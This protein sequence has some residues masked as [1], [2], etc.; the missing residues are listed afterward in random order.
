M[1]VG[2]MSADRADPVDPVLQKKVNQVVELTGRS[3]DEVIVALH[4]CDNDANRA[5]NHL[6]EGDDQGEWKE[7][8]SKRKKRQPAT[9]KPVEDTS[10]ERREKSTD[11]RR[12]RDDRFDGA[13]SRRGRQPPRLARKN[14]QNREFEENERNRNDSASQ[15]RDR[16][17]FGKDFDKGFDR[18]FDRSF[19]DDRRGRG[20]GRGGGP[21]RGGRGGGRGRREGRGGGPGGPRY[22]R[23]SSGGP[24]IGTWTNESAEK[25]NSQNNFTVSTWEDMATE[26]DWDTEWTGSVGTTT[27]EDRGYTKVNL[28][29]T[30]TFISSAPVTDTFSNDTSSAFTNNTSSAY[31]NDTSSAYTNDTGSNVFG[32]VGADYNQHDDF[33]QNDSIFPSHSSDSASHV[34]TNSLV[35]IAT[36]NGNVAFNDS[37]N[38]LHASALETAM[39]ANA[40]GNTDPLNQNSL[41]DDTMQNSLPASNIGQP[42]TLG[43][44]LDLSMLL[45]SAEAEAHAQKQQSQFISQFTKPQP[46][47][48]YT[49]N[50]NNS[51]PQLPIH[52]ST[53]SLPHHNNV[54]Q[55]LPIH[56]SAQ[57][58]TALQHAALTLNESYGSVDPM[59]VPMSAAES[60]AQVTAGS[61]TITS[62]HSRA[63]QQAALTQ[64]MNQSR[65]KP[66]KSKLPP[67]SKIPATAVEMPGH[68][69]GTMNLDVQFGNWDAGFVSF[70]TVP[71]EQSQSVS[72]SPTISSS[73]PPT[74]HSNHLP[75][76][77]STSDHLAANALHVTSVIH[78]VTSPPPGL[79]VNSVMTTPP[80]A[81]IPASPA[82]SVLD[83]VCSNANIVTSPPKQH[84][85]FP[86]SQTSPQQP[87]YSKP[88]AVTSPPD[89]IPFPSD[90]QP[91][92]YGQRT[93]STGMSTGTSLQ[94]KVGGGAVS[95]PGM[96][97]FPPQPYA[98]SYQVYSNSSTNNKQAVSASDVQSSQISSSSHSQS[99]PTQYPSSFHSAVSPGNAGSVYSNQTAAP[100]S[101]YQA[102]NSQS[103]FPGSQSVPANPS[104]QSPSAYHSRESVQPATVPFPPPSGNSNSQSNSS[105]YSAGAASGAYQSGSSQSSLNQSNVSYSATAGVSQSSNSPYARESQSN[106]QVSSS[107]YTRDSTIIQSQTG[108]QSSYPGQSSQNQQHG[109]YAPSN[110][111][112]SSTN[113]SSYNATPLPVTTQ[114]YTS[115]PIPNNP[116]AATTQSYT[117]HQSSASTYGSTREQTSSQSYGQTPRENPS[118]QSFGPTSRDN[119][120]SYGAPSRDNVPSQSYGS[121]SL[122][123]P[124]SQSYGSRDNAT[125]QSYG[126]TSRDSTSSK[127]YG[128]APRDN[129]APQ[130]YGST[131]RENT[132]SQSY[133]TTS[134]DNT[135]SQSFG[136]SSRDSTPSQS[137][138]SANHQ[139]NSLPMAS[140][141]LTDSLQKMTVKD[142][143]SPSQYG[144]D[145]SNTAAVSTGVIPSTLSTAAPAFTGSPGSVTSVLGLTTSSNTSTLASMPA[146][147][148]TVPGLP[149]TSKAPPNLPPGVPPLM[150]NYIPAG[151]PFT[152]PGLPQQTAIYS[153]EDLQLLQRLPVPPST[154]TGMT[155]PREYAAGDGKGLPTRLDA[156]SPVT[157]GGGP[158]QGGSQQQSQQA[159]TQQATH[160]PF[161]NPTLPPGYNYYYP[162]LVPGGYSAYPPAMFPSNMVPPVTQNTG[163]G[164]SSGGAAQFQKPAGYGG[165]HYGTATYDDLSTQAQDFAKTAYQQ[166]APV[167]SKVGVTSAVTANVSG[168]IAA[169]GKVSYGMTQHAPGFDKAAFAAAT[170]PPFNMAMSASGSQAGPMGPGAY[171]APYMP[172]MAHQPHSQM[173]HHHLQ[174]LQKEVQK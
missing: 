104:Y 39:N 82:Q 100:P 31:T 29:E 154:L 102:Q 67:P 153:Y 148:H 139:T 62:M 134:R 119:T 27:N 126:S 169:A 81:T 157:P 66:Q 44:R 161:M 128:S 158:V 34:F 38:T 69:P 86:N 123:K 137:Y 51:Q 96:P 52:N 35:T 84:S 93:T 49:N 14:N 108:S 152:F 47:E 16:G 142:N 22:D 88:S 56:N 116:H 32:S 19:G 48:S 72:Y 17:G 77:S 42:S 111:H 33:A 155:A 150:G 131:S 160:Q 127:S 162:G 12:E 92:Q 105:S 53:N 13:P 90:R 30:T 9:T 3:K 122:D 145:T 101:L 130:S 18:N 68:L 59:S 73:P 115:H 50:T 20:R 65:P 159:A 136:S 172:V 85:A 143:I 171:G 163:H 89:P 46:T 23:S 37:T 75:S 164:S 98:A 166:A 144:A 26:G 71:N 2:Q 174:Q 114:S 41:H 91:N 70:G 120:S 118:S 113:S 60:L 95:I 97:G 25:E 79:P 106:S 132:P 45:K 57:S 99:G 11:G 24:S 76:V 43:Q 83:A 124:A 147:K 78:H 165:T 55:H 156:Q 80:P 8:S 74:V 6:L 129:T 110:T 140:N 4:D 109:G 5:I 107:P 173:L 7:T 64:V 58:Q 138:G 167:Q 117:N 36:A 21:G 54:T 63:A 170:P 133:G 135:P 121:T 15:D 87:S 94:S 1:R 141:N 149:I 146:T 151:L 10:P 112:Q 103:A 61:A 125:T 28:E 40:I 168:D